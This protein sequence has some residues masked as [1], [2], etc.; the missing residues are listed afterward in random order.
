MHD[1]NAFMQAEAEI[2][3]SRTLVELQNRLEQLYQTDLSDWAQLI[4]FSKYALA[5]AAEL[6]LG[7]LENIPVPNRLDD[8]PHTEVRKQ[9]VTYKI[10]GVVHDSY[11]HK[12]SHSVKAQIREKASRYQN[13][14]ASEGSVLEFGLGQNF[15]LPS[16]WELNSYHCNHEAPAGLFNLPSNIEP[17]VTA[18]LAMPTTELTRQY[19]LVGY[20]S[21]KDLRCLPQARELYRRTEVPPPL[22]FDVNEQIKAEIAKAQ[23]QPSV[24]AV[25]KD[26]LWPF[27]NLAL[28]QKL[29]THQD[30]AFMAEQLQAYAKKTG[31][32]TVHLITGLAHEAQV[33]F[34]L[35]NP[36]ELR[37]IL[38]A[39]NRMR[40][41]P[42]G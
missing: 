13:Q 28:Y 31:Y 15:G 23:K 6:K 1:S 2:R 30:S 7:P 20:K 18:F 21:T 4:F 11:I 5:R 22:S 3:S 42:D 25:Y 39:T 14:P 16:A 34:L 40:V 41:S 19:L 10:H 35:N 26:K 33:A 38:A 12:I 8:L 24:G 32:R 17:L 37:S 29:R 9:T 36:D 27:S